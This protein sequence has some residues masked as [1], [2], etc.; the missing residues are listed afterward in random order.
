MAD[1][2]TAVLLACVRRK[3]GIVISEPRRRARPFCWWRAR[4]DWMGTVRYSSLLASYSYGELSL[5]VH[6]GSRGWFVLD[7]DIAKS[8]KS[9]GGFG[10]MDGWMDYA[11]CRPLGMRCVV[12][13]SALLSIGI[14]S[15]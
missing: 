11:C 2:D 4:I 1:N 9:V 5:V 10:R 6:S 15:M 13:L 14:A 8:H 12:L 3:L 7:N